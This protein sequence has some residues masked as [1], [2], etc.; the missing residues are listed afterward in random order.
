MTGASEIPLS[1]VARI[2]R[3]AGAE[4]VSSDTVD[5]LAALMEEHAVLVTRE[6]LKLMHHAGR[7]TLRATDITMAAEIL[8]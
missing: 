5:T 4:R 7:K 2:I 6:A 3:N 8:R 1:P